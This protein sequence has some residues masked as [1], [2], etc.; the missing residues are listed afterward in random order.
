MNDIYDKFYGMAKNGDLDN[1]QVKMA[2]Q[3]QG[4]FSSKA[5]DNESLPDFATR[6]SS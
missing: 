1:I 2:P 5:S 6:P 4:L 3:K